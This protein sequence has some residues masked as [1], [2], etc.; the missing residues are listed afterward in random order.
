MNASR[1]P[2]HNLRVVPH[3]PARDRFLLVA[4]AASVLLAGAIGFWAGTLSAADARDAAL[5]ELA[6]VS[7]EYRDLRG[8][9]T[10]LER[11]LGDERL[12]RQVGGVFSD[13]VRDTLGEQSSRIRE[14]EEQIRFYRNLMAGTDEGEL[15]I[16]DLELLQRLDGRGVR[17]R[18]LLVQAS[19]RRNE[20][21]GFV[22]VRIIGL[23]GGKQE[24]LSGAVMGHDLDSPMPIRFRYFQRLAG[25]IRLPADFEPQGVEVIARSGDDDGFN[26]Q[27]TFSWALQE[28]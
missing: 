15:Q 19:D 6:L 16:A 1:T 10:Y 4:A 14:L 26:L 24:V 18:L 17:F 7:D 23:R 25:E 28:V 2:A 8:Q 21:T 12:A 13:Q 11:E 5:R 9:Y 20:I 22:D 3:R 27:R